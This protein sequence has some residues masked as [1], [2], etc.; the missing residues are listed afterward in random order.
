MLAEPPHVAQ[1]RPPATREDCVDAITSE[2]RRHGCRRRD[3]KIPTSAGLSP[4]KHVRSEHTTC[5]DFRLLARRSFRRRSLPTRTRKASYI[6]SVLAACPSV[7]A[8]TPRND[9]RPV[10]VP[11]RLDNASKSDRR[12]VPPKVSRNVALHV[13]SSKMSRCSCKCRDV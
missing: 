9:G 3:T 12:N 2:E 5:F 11:G 10:V 6:T 13:K 7:G 8:N 4:T 1:R